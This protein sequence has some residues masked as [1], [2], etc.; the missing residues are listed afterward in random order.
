MAP[1]NAPSNWAAMYGTA[2]D[3]SPD[4]TAKPT[5]TAG[6]RCAAVLPQAIAVKTPAMTANAQ[7]AVIAIQ[8]APPAL[9]LFR[10]TPATTPF[11]SRIKIQVP[12]NSP[13]IVE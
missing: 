1:V 3:Q 10:T 2:F 13:S 7:P 8:P 5:V 4:A 11:P 6:F 12:K 9:D